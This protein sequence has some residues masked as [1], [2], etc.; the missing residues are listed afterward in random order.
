V[1][2]VGRNIRV[3]IFTVYYASLGKESRGLID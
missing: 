2:R 3:L 1:G